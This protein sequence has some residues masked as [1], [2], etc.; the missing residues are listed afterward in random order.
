M[1]V[2]PEMLERL[3]EQAPHASIVLTPELTLLAANATARRLIGEDRLTIGAALFT[4]L[5]EPSTT[6]DSWQMRLRQSYTDMLAS[7]RPLTLMLPARSNM[8]AEGRMAHLEPGAPASAIWHVCHAPL[9]DAAGNMIAIATH[10]H[11]L[12]GV[13]IAIAQVSG[14]A[15]TQVGAMPALS[16]SSVPA[17]PAPVAP[18]NAISA[19]AL[20]DPTDSA[21]VARARALHVLLVE[22]ND[23]LRMATHEQLQLLGHRVTDVAD[24]EQAMRLL[25]GGR[26]DLLF[27]DL[28]LP[29]MTGAELARVVLQREQTM[30]VVITSGYGRALANAQSL[31]ALFL[32]K[33]YQFNDLEDVLQ[34]VQKRRQRA[35]DTDS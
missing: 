8:D 27:T 20:A 3:F 33:P 19:H 29:K 2:M 26:F 24:A 7:R 25:E 34:Q 32:P 5:Q 18:S 12:A 14:S 15:T 16:A 6:T 17:E 23:D 11:A 31:D 4:L 30:Q 21:P 13:E 28:T 9:F 22:D 1:N 35:P 10:A